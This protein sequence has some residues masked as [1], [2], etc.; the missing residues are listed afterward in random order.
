MMSLTRRQF[1]K[2]AIAAVPSVSQLARPLDLFA[3]G[4]KPNSLLSGVQLGTITYSYRSMPDQS[5]EAT[6]RYIVDSGIS[7]IELM[8]GPA[9]I[10][11]GAPSEGRRGGG[12]GRPS[13][14]L[15]AGGQQPTPEQQAAQRA[16]A[17][18]LKHWRTSVSMDRFKALRKMYNDA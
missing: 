16:A 7:A 10:F 18:R 14:A 1:G 3:Q 9:E 5:A 12:G 13:T 4:H 11:A 15:G 2:L 17:D 6:L 8:N